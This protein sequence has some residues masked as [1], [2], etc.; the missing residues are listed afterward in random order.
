MFLEKS[1]NISK[2]AKLPEEYFPEAIKIMPDFYEK[3]F[4]PSDSQLH[5]PDKFTEFVTKRRENIFDTIKEVLIY[6]N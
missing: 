5:K 2:K 6:Q 1:L 3:N 4:I